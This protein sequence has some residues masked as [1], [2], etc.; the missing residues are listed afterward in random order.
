MDKVQSFIDN[1]DLRTT[2]DFNNY[3]KFNNIH[4]EAVRSGDYSIISYLNE[5]YTDISRMFNYCFVNQDGKVVHYFE[6]KQY[7]NVSLNGLKTGE[8]NCIDLS[9]C[10]YSHNTVM[11]NEGSLIKV[12]F[13]GVKWEFSTSRR[14]DAVNTYWTSNEKSF[15]EL[16]YEAVHESD[17]DPVFVKG[18]CYTFLLQH[19][20]NFITLPVSKN[21]ILLNKIN[22]STFEV[23]RTGLDNYSFK[24][25]RIDDIINGENRNICDNYIVY[26]TKLLTNEEFRIKLTSDAYKERQ[27]IVGNSQTP[28]HVCINAIISNTQ[29]KFVKVLPDFSDILSKVQE[30]IHYTSETVLAAYTMKYI[31]KRKIKIDTRL[32]YIIQK[33]HEH[34]LETRKRITLLDIK[35]LI[36]DLNPNQIR[37]IL[38]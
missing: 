38:V 7:E 12:F 18:F 13:D 8:E 19:P 24:Y 27:K 5:N 33:C 20:E 26:G 10:S 23:D 4:C 14:I 28:E 16:F 21:V 6:P 9:D 15:K 32:D 22:T 35:D 3:F 11:Y 1:N 25:K 30:R 2:E 36:F 17:I 34:F 29:D 37:A 31:V